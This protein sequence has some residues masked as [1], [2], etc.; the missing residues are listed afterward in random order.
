M[1]FEIRPATQ[2]DFPDLQNVEYAAFE[3]LKAAGAVAGEPVASSAEELQRCLDDGFLLAA[4]DEN[5]QPVG[6]SSA[7]IVG[8][9]IYIAELD[10]HPDSQRQGLGRRLTTTLLDSAR[11]RGFSAATLTTDRLAPFNA[12]FYMSLGFQFLEPPERPRYLTDILQ[13]QIAVGADPARR[14]A[15]RLRF[16]ML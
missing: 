14:V 5:D 3:T 16:Q 11:A 1:T 2:A 4:C 6:Y 13:R 10:V 15:M 12:P 7:Y 9:E 8:D